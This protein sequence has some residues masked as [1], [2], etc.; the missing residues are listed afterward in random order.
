VILEALVGITSFDGR[1][2][3]LDEVI[4]HRAAEIARVVPIDSALPFTLTTVRNRHAWTV[5]RGAN[6][7]S[8]SHVGF[9]S[10]RVLAAPR[11]KSHY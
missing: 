11:R 6:Q 9:S 8:G 7:R 3:G 5:E 1:V 4:D 10:I 2:T